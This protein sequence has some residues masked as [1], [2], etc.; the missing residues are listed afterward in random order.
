MG[1]S[2]TY[3]KLRTKCFWKNMF[4]DICEY[5]TSCELCAVTKW[6]ARALIAPLILIAKFIERFMA[7]STDLVG[8]L[9]NSSKG[10]QYLLVLVDFFTH[11]AKVFPLKTIYGKYQNP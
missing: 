8:P 4:R 1:H 3:A 7:W 6:P 10:N 9:Q 11:R 5:I 2:K